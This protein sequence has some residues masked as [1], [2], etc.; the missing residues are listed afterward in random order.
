ML[1]YANRQLARMLT[2]PSKR[3]I[4]PVAREDNIVFVD[5]ARPCRADLLKTLLDQ[6]YGACV[7]FACVLLVGLQ[8]S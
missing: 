8:F 2:E 6:A 1:P 3:L 7:M 5:H 4:R